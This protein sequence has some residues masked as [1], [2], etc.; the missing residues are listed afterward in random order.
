MKVC[1]VVLNS[2]WFDP[3]VR[4]QIAEYLANGIDLCCVGK[5]CNRYDEEKVNQMP[6]KTVIVTPDPRYEGR[7]KSVFRKL[8][9]ER[10]LQEAIRD[11]II[12]QKPDII[13][14]NDLNALI[15]AYMA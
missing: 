11:A 13:H 14:A 1:D 8:K 4:K 10:L 3:R 2:V 12:E 5:K 7:Q 9:R 6:C 15:P